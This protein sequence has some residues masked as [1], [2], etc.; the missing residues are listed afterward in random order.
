MLLMTS[1]FAHYPP[2]GV[3]RNICESMYKGMY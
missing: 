3:C 1:Y 2:L